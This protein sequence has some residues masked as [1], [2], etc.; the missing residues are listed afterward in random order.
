MPTFDPT[1]PSGL[2]LDGQM[3]N[4]RVPKS[5]PCDLQRTSELQDSGR[6]P[7]VAIQQPTQRLRR[8]AQS[9]VAS[10][11]TVI[12]AARSAQAAR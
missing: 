10:Q 1:G 3:P 6:P 11:F 7:T 2:L 4:A 8:G 5:Q 12:K 9:K